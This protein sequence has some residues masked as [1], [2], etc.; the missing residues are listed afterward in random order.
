MA[1][2]AA[3][4]IGLNL[5]LKRER[6]DLAVELA[7]KELRRIGRFAPNPDDA[8]Q[9][10]LLE[11]L[12]G[13]ATLEHGFTVEKLRRATEEEL[14][15]LRL[16]WPGGAG[17]LEAVLKRA[18]P[19]E[20]L[21]VAPVEPDF[22]G[23]ALVLMALARPDC[24]TGPERWKSWCATVLR[25]AN[26]DS[27]ATPA[28]LL[29]AFQNFGHQPKYGEPLLAATD[30]LIR[31]GLAEAGPVLLVGLED[32]LPHQTVELRSRAG[33][34]T[35]HLYAR[36]KAA[37]EA[38]RDNLKPEVARLANNLANRLSALGRRAEALAPAQ[39]A[40]ALRRALARAHPDA[41]NPDLARSLNNLALLLSELGRR[42]EA[43]A[44]AQEAVGLYR[45]LARA[46]P[47]AFN[48]DLASS[49]GALGSVLAANKHAAEARAC[50]AEGIGVLTPAFRVLPEAHQSL[51]AFLVEVYQELSTALGEAPDA[52]LL[53][54]V[55]PLLNAGSAPLG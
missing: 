1:A 51:M 19:G 46:N 9:Q 34:V 18:L 45:A 38:G 7:R 30:A 12:T 42:A 39:E 49:L 2:L 40:V 28:T 55:L 25:C 16:E 27:R 31:A 3:V 8:I 6:V 20:R 35:R 21:P 26:R 37:M 14:Q 43:L 11:H 48:P 13:C 23:E 54:P 4:E 47:D 36:L 10:R 22:L 50:F 52:A 33:E 53:G 29:H 17:A 32:A 15:A 41:F 44:P 5:A 24:E